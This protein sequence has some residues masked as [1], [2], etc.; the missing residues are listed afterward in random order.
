MLHSSQHSLFAEF[1]TL[2]VMYGQPSSDFIVQEPPYILV[3]DSIST[4][5]GHT[6]KPL[7]VKRTYSLLTFLL[8]S[9][10]D[11]EQMFVHGSSTESAPVTS[12]DAG[13]P[14]AG[15]MGNLL[16]LEVGGQ[17]L[18]AFVCLNF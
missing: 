12:Q 7:G 3:N 5:R 10:L 1:N 9:D 15:L 8:C 14:V 16:D 18:N 11:L 6:H 2:A 13:K 17:F 4:R